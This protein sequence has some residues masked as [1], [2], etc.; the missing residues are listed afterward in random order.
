MCPSSFCWFVVS[1]VVRSSSG[2][3]PPF[4]AP[5]PVTCRSLA[6][7]WK[8]WRSA[9]VRM[10]PSSHMF[11]RS[12]VA[13]RCVQSRA[14]WN[15]RIRQVPLYISLWVLFSCPLIVFL[16]DAMGWPCPFAKKHGE[17]EGG[18]RTSRAAIE[19]Q[20]NQGGEEALKGRWG[21]EW[22]W[23]MELRP[24]ELMRTG[25]L[26]TCV[27]APSFGPFM[28]PPLMRQ[29]LTPL[30]PFSWWD[31]RYFC[32]YGGWLPGAPRPF[33]LVDGPGG[34]HP[35]IR[36]AFLQSATRGGLQGELFHLGLVRGS[37]W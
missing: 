4:I 2:R 9:K 26:M 14:S 5:P 37:G 19:G 20:E 31:G 28:M 16:S 33:S 29:R 21:W 24:T 18:S 32:R 1:P 10:G 22:W 27:R 12:L 35:S 15:L 6:G 8:P 23:H 34:A 30:W 3:P 25:T 17:E 13:P 7:S 11:S 36:R